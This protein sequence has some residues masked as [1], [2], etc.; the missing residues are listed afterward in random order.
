MEELAK[1]EPV[2]QAVVLVPLAILLITC[3]YTDFKDRKVYNKVTYPSFFIGLAVNAIAF[4]WAGLLDGFLA[5]LIA[6]GI[7]LVLLIT[8][9]VGGGDIKLLI[10]VGAF[11]GKLGL[12]EV[13]FYSVIAGAVG[14]LVA[15]LFNGYLLEM[16]KRMGRWFRGLYRAAIYRTG[17]MYEKLE[18]DERS[19]IPFA[20]AILVGGILTWTDAVYDWPGLFDIF[21]AAWRV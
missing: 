13:T 19:W 14:G 7:G 9:M 20:I 10:V 15:A 6:F 16:L 8:G 2:R 5:A 18:R 11:L 4:G 12:A 1:L 21:V 17:V 3:A